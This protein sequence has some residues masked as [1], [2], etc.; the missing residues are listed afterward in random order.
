MLLPTNLTA[1]GL[2]LQYWLPKL[3][4]AVWVTVFGA[5]L[6]GLNLLH[7]SIYGKAQFY[8]VSRK[9]CQWFSIAFKVRAD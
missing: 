4:T 1:S 7:V 8:F 5:A 9:P 2:I 3:N 6:L